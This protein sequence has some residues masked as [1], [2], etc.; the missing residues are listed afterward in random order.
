MGVSLTQKQEKRRKGGKQNVCICGLA[1]EGG[2]HPKTSFQA[3]S[4]R[5]FLKRN[6][7]VR[8]EWTFSK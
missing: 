2:S 1:I 6:C 4:E 5:Q 3:I 8:I 7:F